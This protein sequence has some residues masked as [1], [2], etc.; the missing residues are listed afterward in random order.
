MNIGE[1][2]K[3]LR[4]DAGLTQEQLGALLGIQ[5]ASVGINQILK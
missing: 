2:I 1:R 5:K 4:N 3:K